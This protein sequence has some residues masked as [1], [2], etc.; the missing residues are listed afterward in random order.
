M[1]ESEHIKRAQRVLCDSLHYDY[2]D[3]SEQYVLNSEKTAKNMIEN[4]ILMPPV[5]IGQKVYAVIALDGEE[6]VSA[7]KVGGVCYRDGKW[8]AF[9]E[10]VSDEFEIGSSLCMLTKDDA[11][12]LVRA[13]LPEYCKKKI[14]DM[15]QLHSV[16]TS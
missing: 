10:K 3:F 16:M 8:Y 13:N 4:G 14:S 15:A 7:Y 9:E 6:W 5:C 12:A 2:D 1:T 11:E